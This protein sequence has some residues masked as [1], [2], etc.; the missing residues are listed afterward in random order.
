MGP[1]G[2]CQTPKWGSAHRR[3]AGTLCLSLSFPRCPG[4]HQLLLAS[5]HPGP[6]LGQAWGVAPSPGSLPAWVLA[7]P[8]PASGEPQPQGHAL[9]SPCSSC[10][11][12]VPR[13]P[14]I[15]VLLL[16]RYGEAMRAPVQEETAS[17]TRIPRGSGL[18][19]VQLTAP[20]RSPPLLKGTDP[21]LGTPGDLI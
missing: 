7:G 9:L 17:Y 4:T 12:Q 20:R 11:G 14:Q 6:S 5:T 16:L 2:L 21:F 19:S 15:Q 10:S 18:P 1:P 3:A 13:C 8:A